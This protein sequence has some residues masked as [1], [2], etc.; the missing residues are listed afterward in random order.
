VI[1]VYG[2]SQAETKKFPLMDEKLK[3]DST[4]IRELKVSMTD[5]DEG[6]A[7]EGLDWT[8]RFIRD[9]GAYLDFKALLDDY[10][11]EVSV[12]S[13]G[14]AEQRIRAEVETGYLRT[15]LK[16][17]ENLLAKDQEIPSRDE[18]R[19]DVGSVDASYL[20]LRT[21]A[22]A[23]KVTLY[24]LEEKVRRLKDQED[25]LSM[26]SLFV[27]NARS[28]LG[29]QYQGET[30]GA[31][32]RGLKA[33][34]ESMAKDVPPGNLPQ[35]Q[36]LSRI[37]GDVARIEGRYSVQLSELSRRVEPPRATLTLLAGA[38]FGG[39]FL[40]FILAFGRHK[41]REYDA[42]DKRT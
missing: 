39:G 40:G 35:Q 33:I 1:P 30:S 11:S 20:P 13:S 22:N 24:S 28:I 34:A 7:R 15:R 32:T 3:A 17:F 42:A 12:F 36:A 5:R 10:Q 9:G 23:L 27:E 19:V 26:L 29:A 25:A 8:L 2:I 4:V 21:Q 37:R 38:T 14:F 41:L 16:D 18:I 6:H 31:L